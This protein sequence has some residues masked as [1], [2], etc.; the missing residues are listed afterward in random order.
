MWLLF[1]RPHRPDFPVWPGRHV[2][3]LLDAVLWPALIGGYAFGAAQI[4]P[5]IVTQVVFSACVVAALVRAE[6][7]VFENQHYR[8]TTWRWARN[9]L[10]VLAFGAGLKLAG[11]S[12]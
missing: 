4:V 7:A 11:L 3:A 6:R 9:A 1:T 12:G 8:F 2:L 5:G 10:I